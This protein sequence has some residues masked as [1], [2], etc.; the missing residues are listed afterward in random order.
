MCAVYI[1]AKTDKKLFL[2]K[3]ESVSLVVS[4]VVE[5]KGGL[6]GFVIYQRVV[7]TNTYACIDKSFL[8]ENKSNTSA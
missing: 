4:L 7:C 3:F 5:G 8:K 2:Y 6:R 1:L